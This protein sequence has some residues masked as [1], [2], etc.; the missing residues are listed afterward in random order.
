VSI[1]KV[2]VGVALQRP[3]R[4][5]ATIY[6]TLEADSGN[7]AELLACQI[8]YNHPRVVMPVSSV[9]TDWEEGST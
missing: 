8:A 5:D 9:V 1:F 6:Y 4:H 2:E 7:A 3:P